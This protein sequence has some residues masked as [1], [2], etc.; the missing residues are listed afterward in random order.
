MLGEL[1]ETRHALWKREAE[2]AAGVPLIP[3]EDEQEHLAAQ[4]EAVLRAGAQAVGCQAA[5][6]YLLDEA[7]TELKLR[8]SWGLPFDRLTA[9][10][11]PLKG[12]IAD[13]EALLGHAVVLDDTNLMCQWR[14]PED[15]P[16]A[17][18]L[19]VS[20]PTILLG[21]LWFFCEQRRD[22]DE[23]Q[24]EILEVV[25]G[26]LAADLE[27]EMLMHEA[28]DG[29]E[30][31]KQLAAA[32]RLQRNQLPSISP[33]LTGWELAGWTAQSKTV[34][35]D[36]HDWF[37]LPNGLLA[38]AVGDAMNQG[39][40]AAMAATALKTALRTCGQYHREAAEVLKQ[41]NRTL[42]A[43]SG[44]DQYATVFYAL[45]DTATGRIDC[46]TAGE[47]AVVVVR[48]DG[49]ESLSRRSVRLGSGPEAASESFHYHLQPG[50][51][52]AVFTDGFRDAPNPAGTPLGE[53]AVAR[54]IASQ[55]SLAGRAPGRPPPGITSNHIA[56]VATHDDRTLLVIKRTKG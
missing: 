6:L 11:R 20:T 4:L 53:E 25:A 5:A 42:W 26:R 13:L 49:W 50:E 21:T 54:L 38:V 27:R 24:T 31:K 3:H 32:E 7:T 14:V 10:A 40:E 43:G 12:S 28:V 37:C 22:F 29:A 16:A 30:L 2:L 8:S 46:A 44:G 17:V 55:P 39:I 52:I 36:F 47:P 34:G 33:L 56:S 9:P 41:V 1:I 18:C 48:S 35:G 23:R 51:A 15:Y 45:I 19:P